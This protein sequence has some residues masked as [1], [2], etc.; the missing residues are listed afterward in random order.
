M[1]HPHHDDEPHWH[2]DQPKG[3]WVA[4]AIIW[5]CTVALICVAIAVAMTGATL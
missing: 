4:G 1:N 2:E 5:A 3:D